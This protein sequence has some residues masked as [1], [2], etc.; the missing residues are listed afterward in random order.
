[1]KIISSQ[2]YIND[3]IVEEKI[4]NL[5]KNEV[6]AVEIPCEEIGSLDGEEYA[7]QIDGHHTL[8]AARELGLEIKFVISGKVD[9]YEQYD[10]TEDRLTAHYADSDWYY[11]ETSNPYYNEF[12][13]VW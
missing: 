1:M 4:Q 9:D 2:G 6:S 5:Q 10:N 7:I 13:M 11:V 8:A 12:D 3:K